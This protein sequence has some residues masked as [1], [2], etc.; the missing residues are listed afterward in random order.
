[1]DYIQIILSVIF[2]NVTTPHEKFYWM[3]F[4]ISNVRLSFF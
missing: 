3:Y 4:E 1:M 2:D